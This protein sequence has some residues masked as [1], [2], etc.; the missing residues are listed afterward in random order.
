MRILSEGKVLKEAVGQ[1]ALAGTLLE[2][3]A[4]A[5]PYIKQRFVEFLNDIRPQQDGDGTAYINGSAIDITTL[6][7][8]AA[9]L[10]CCV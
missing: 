4:C 8:Y 1:A 9:D 3:V 2:G 7:A 5:Y 6:D 10:P